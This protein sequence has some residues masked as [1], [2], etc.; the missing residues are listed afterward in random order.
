MPPC[1]LL[2]SSLDRQRQHKSAGTLSNYTEF[3]PGLAIHADPALQVAGEWRSPPGRLLELN[4]QMG[5]TGAWIGLHLTFDAPNLSSYGW[6][7]FTCRSAAPKTFMIRPCLRSGTDGGFIDCFF[8]KHVLTDPETRNHVDTLHLATNRCLPRTA[9]WR[10]LIL[11]L[12]R[13]DFRLHLHDLR[14]FFV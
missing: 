10:E 2:D 3:C 9:P 11:F 1:V 4:V 14:P 13:Q 5:A 6:I 12:P 8:D 7:G